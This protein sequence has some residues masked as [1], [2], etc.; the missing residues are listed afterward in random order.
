MVP[1]SSS[2]RAREYKFQDVP[3]SLCAARYD[4]GGGLFLVTV[5]GFE[6]AQLQ[7]C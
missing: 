1:L 7:F 5:S 2:Q 3:G 4:N 6:E